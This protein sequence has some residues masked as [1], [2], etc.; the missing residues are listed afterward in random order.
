MPNT[1]LT[2]VSQ[3]KVGEI[4]N[5]DYDLPARYRKQTRGRKNGNFEVTDICEN[6]LVK[7]AEL[8]I[9]LKPLDEHFYKEYPTITEFW[10]HEDLL[11][12]RIAESRK[13]D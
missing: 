7:D 2:K 8:L 1:K 5:L 13:H 10:Q 6:S 12:K 3:F 11:A 9:Y 4:I